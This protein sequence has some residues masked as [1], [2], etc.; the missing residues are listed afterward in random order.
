MYIS[1]N[2][3][4][5]G[6]EALFVTASRRVDAGHTET[7]R[8]RLRP[9]DDRGNI[10]ALL[11]LPDELMRQARR[12]RNLQRGAVRAQLALVV[13]VLLMAPIRMSNLVKLDIERNLVRPG[14]GRALHRH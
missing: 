4:W 9:L 8:T 2:A 7:N 10:I 13:E 12:H 1:S 11:K 6:W 5:I 3:I 14:Q